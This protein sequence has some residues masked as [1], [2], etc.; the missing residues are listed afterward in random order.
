MAQK[1]LTTEEK[2]DQLNLSK[3]KLSVLQDT[4]K[5]GEVIHRLGGNIDRHC[6]CMWVSIHLCLK[7]L[8]S[9]ICKNL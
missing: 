6:V 5:N 4:I 1:A 7:G 9:R 8:I 2:I 3:L